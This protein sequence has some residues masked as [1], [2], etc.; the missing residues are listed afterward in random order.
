VIRYVVLD[1]GVLGLLTHPPAAREALDGD[2][3]LAAQATELAASGAPVIV[4]TTNPKHLGRY[5]TAQLWTAI[6]VD[7]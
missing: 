1:T 5:V 3:I 4:A 6:V 2:V 7:K